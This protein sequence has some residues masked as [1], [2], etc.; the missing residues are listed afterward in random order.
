MGYLARVMT[1][2]EAV[3]E[4]GRAEPDRE[5]VLAGVE[6]L[7]EADVVARPRASAGRLLEGQILT[8]VLVE[9]GADRRIEIGSIEQDAPM[10]L[11]LDLSVTG[12]AGCQPAACMAQSTSS[13]EPSRPTLIASPESPSTVRVVA[14]SPASFGWCSKWRQ[15]KG[16]RI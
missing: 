16:A 6:R 11:T 2:A 14:S 15:K 12:S 13:S 9:Q 4:N 3:V 7:P 5:A 1:D 8:S 10:I